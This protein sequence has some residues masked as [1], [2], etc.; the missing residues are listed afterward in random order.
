MCDL[1]VKKD[2]DSVD[3]KEV[4]DALDNIGEYSSLL[5]IDIL[6]N[7]IRQMELLKEKQLKQ[8]TKNIPSLLKKE[9]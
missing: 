5:S 9:N 1:N 8:Y 4:N 7:F 3:F 2:W 6:D